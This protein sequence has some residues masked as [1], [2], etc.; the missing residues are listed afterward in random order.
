MTPTP[1]ILRDGSAVL[2]DPD[3][4]EQVA[5]LAF[6][7]DPTSGAVVRK[8]REGGR[9]KTQTLA[10]FVMGGA[11]PPGQLW[12]HAN[13]DAGDFRRENLRAVRRGTHL[14]EGHHR[15]AGQ[16]SAKAGRARKKEP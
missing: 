2:L 5:N 14:P 7:R 11:A 9:V 1:V 6:R 8:Y 15:K 12:H 16:A 3:A 4:A 10:Q 13:G